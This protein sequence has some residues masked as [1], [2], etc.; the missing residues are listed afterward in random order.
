[1]VIIAVKNAPNKEGKMY[2]PDGTACGM[3][4]RALHSGETAYV[5]ILERLG[6]LYM[7]RQCAKK[8]KKVSG[9]N[10]QLITAEVIDYLPKGSHIV[11]E[12]GR[13]ALSGGEVDY[14]APIINHTKIAGREEF[15]LMPPPDRPSL[16]QQDKKLEIELK[17]EKELDKFFAEKTPVPTN[18]NLLDHIL[19]PEPSWAELHGNAQVTIEDK[20]TKKQIEEKK[21]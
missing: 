5:R 1:M 12:K 20:S 17:T 19:P 4:H 6:S 9:I 10:Q 16:E 13:I 21:E 3:C 8:T 15:N 14:N 18:F 7:C 11:D 2:I